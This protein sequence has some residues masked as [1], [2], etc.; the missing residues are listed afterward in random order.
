MRV[1]ELMH[2]PAVTCTP[3]YM[4]SAVAQAHG[5][6]GRGQAPPSS[7]RRRGSGHRDRPRHHQRGRGPAPLRCISPVEALM[8]RSVALVYRRADIA[9]TAATTTHSR[10]PV[11]DDRGHVHGLVADDIVLNV[12]RQTDEVGRCPRSLTVGILRLHMSGGHEACQRCT[13]TCGLLGPSRSG[14]QRSVRCPPDWPGGRRRPIVS[15]GDERHV[16]VAGCWA[17]GNGSYAEQ[18]RAD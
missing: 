6:S 1:S 3:R 7:Q 16:V 10:R 8:T 5:S 4:V 2:T 12:V 9:T 18:T 13:W 14:L 11:V 17:P 15:E